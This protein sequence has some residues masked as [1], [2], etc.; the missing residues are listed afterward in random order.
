MLVN[1]WRE[2][3]RPRIYVF[4]ALTAPKRALKSIKLI[5]SSLPHKPGIWQ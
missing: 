1:F 3:E 4:A 5:G 2:G